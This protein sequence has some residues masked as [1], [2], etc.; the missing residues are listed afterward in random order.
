MDPDAPICVAREL[1]KVFETYHRGTAAEI[2]AEFE[3]QPP[4]G[5][6]VLLIGGTNAPR[7]NGA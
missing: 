7:K 6:I 1:T 4:K 3:K 2:L 5:E